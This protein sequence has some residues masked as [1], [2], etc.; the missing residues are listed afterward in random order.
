MKNI[1]KQFISKASEI[2]ESEVSIED[3]HHEFETAGDLLLAEAKKIIAANSPDNEVK[4]KRLRA[5]GFEKTKEVR[6]TAFQIE[7][8]K[9]AEKMSEEIEYFSIHYP[10]YKF[11]TEKDVKRI[12]GK[13]NLVMGTTTQFTG[14]VPE[15]NLADI[16]AFYEIKD[17]SSGYFAVHHHGY[18]RQ[19]TK[20]VYEQQV[21][22]AA[23]IKDNAMTI[24]TGLSDWR[25][26]TRRVELSIC[27]PVKDMDL[28]DHELRGYKLEK[29]VY[30]D[31]VVLYKVVNGY[32]II[33]SW[34]D[35]ASD[36]DVVNPKS[37]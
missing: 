7:T 36:I 29:K 30:P 5:T 20:E 34:G 1:F 18:E 6:Q 31:P 12:C 8:R 13:Y 3:I 25:Y 22:N 10:Q 15:K 21:N 17:L 33:T 35:E 2:V 23:G 37:N 28:T 32:L 19:L 24:L 4:V 11:I 27:A 9:Q 26:E 16:E 14:F